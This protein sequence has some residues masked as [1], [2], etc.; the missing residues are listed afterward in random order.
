MNN[1]LNS[2]NLFIVSEDNNTKLTKIFNRDLGMKNVC[3]EIK[4]IKISNSYENV[5]YI[6]YWHSKIDEKKILKICNDNLVYYF[7]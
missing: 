3:E 7:K 2:F 6:K 5:E 4:N 1:I